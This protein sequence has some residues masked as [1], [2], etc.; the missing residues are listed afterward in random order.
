METSNV[1]VSETNIPNQLFGTPHELQIQ[2]QSA[3]NA[4]IPSKSA[5]VYSKWLK[6]YQEWAENNQF[7]KYFVSANTL[8]AFFRSFG[9]KYSPSTLWTIFSCLKKQM[10]VHYKIDINQFTEVQHYLKAVNTTHKKKKFPTFSREELDSFLLQAPNETYL[11]HKLI[12]LFATFG[13]LRISEITDLKFENVVEKDGLLQITIER[14]KTDKNGTG[15]IFFVTANANAA[16]CPL[17]YYHA[18][19]VLV[20]SPEPASRLFRQKHADRFTNQVIGKNQI[21]L[22]PKDIASFLKLDNADEYTFHAFRRTGATL[23]A[24]SGV[25]VMQLKQW[26][27]WKSD[28]VAQTY[29]AD[30]SFSKRQL[31]DNINSV[32]TSTRVF[33]ISTSIS[34]ISASPSSTLALSTS[35]PIQDPPTSTVV[36]Q[37]QPKPFLLNWQFTYNVTINIINNKN[38]RNYLND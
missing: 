27:R 17:F 3:R 26:G 37:P 36:P 10:L 30:S 5:A 32:S 11:R 20:N 33:P 18:Y 23:Q 35:T 2:A 31:A 14:S 15:F 34:S 19:K 8:L 38:N 12:L 9:E 22:V 25:S 24:N 1:E 13:G 6:V 16:L 7:S 21:A 28:S 29:V 4:F